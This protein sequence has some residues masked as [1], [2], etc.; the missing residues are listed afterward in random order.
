M[1][2]VR[3]EPYGFFFFGF[4]DTILMKSPYFE[5]IYVYQCFTLSGSYILLLITYD[6]IFIVLGGTVTAQFDMLKQVLLSVG[7]N[8]D[9]EDRAFDIIKESVTHHNM[10]LK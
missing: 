4:E 2:F 6:L 10:L 3:A 1:L 8:E 9:N 7:D 5:L